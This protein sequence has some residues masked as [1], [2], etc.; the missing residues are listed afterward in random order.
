M[1]FMQRYTE[2]SYALLRIVS[3]FLFIWHGST[4][5][6]GFPGEGPAESAMMFYLAGPIEMIG[7]IF[8]CIGFMTRASAFL[9]SGLM[10]AAYWMYHFSPENIFPMLNHGDASILYCFVFLYVAARGAGIWS[11]ESD[12]AD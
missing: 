11:L 3:G 12:S 2:E 10:A 6:L 5:L 9:S 1:G 8:I 4:K 7:G